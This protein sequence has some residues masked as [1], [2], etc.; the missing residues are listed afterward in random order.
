MAKATN[1]KET[2]SAQEIGK[3]Q[4]E[5]VRSTVD[6]NAE[7]ALA[8]FESTEQTNLVQINAEYAEL[9]PN[10]VYN[11]IFTGMTTFK[12][13][14]G[15]DVDAVEFIGKEGIKYISGLSVLVNACR[16]VKQMPCLIRIVTKN[17]VPSKQ[18]GKY[19][20]MNVFVLPQTVNPS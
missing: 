20:D 11:V 10:S 1:T 14:E 19:I 13:R 6:D 7:T 9:K 8:G 3:L 17:E 18:G 2:I 12:N 16:R 5:F 15:K 4:D